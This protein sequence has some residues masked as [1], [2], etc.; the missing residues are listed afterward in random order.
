MSQESDTN[1]WINRVI[2]KLVAE[3]TSL[4]KARFASSE[5]LF[6]PFFDYALLN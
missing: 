6:F 4:L 1:V 5:S 2:G 3:Q